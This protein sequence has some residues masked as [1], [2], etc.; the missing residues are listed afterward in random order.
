MNSDTRMPAS[1]SRAMNGASALCW[2][3]T[4]SPPSVVS[5]SRRSG[6]RHTACG[7]VASAIRS[8]SVGRRHLEIQRL[9]DLGLQPRHVLVA[10][11][12]AVLAQMR[13]DAVGAGLDRDQR[14]AH[15]IGMSAAA[16]VAQGRD[17]VD[18]DAKAQRRSGQWHSW[19]RA[20]IAQADRASIYLERMDCRVKPGNDD[21]AIH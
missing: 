14:G 9:G 18:V 19:F 20:V 11:M 8:M 21:I 2:P 16:R 5:S 17:V 13:G 7:L 3:T 6:T 15:R 1:F 4:S 10:D 12:A